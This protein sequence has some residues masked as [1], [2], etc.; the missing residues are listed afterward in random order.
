MEYST[1]MMDDILWIVSSGVRAMYKRTIESVIWTN[2]LDWQPS[3]YTSVKLP[4]IPHIYKYNIHTKQNVS[5]ETKMY[6]VR[7]TR[8]M[9]HVFVFILQYIYNIYCLHLYELWDSHLFAL[10]TSNSFVRCAVLATEPAR[11]LFLFSQHY[12]P[13]TEKALITHT[14][15]HLSASICLS[16]FLYLSL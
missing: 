15:K 14:S 9:C 3:L 8:I 12:I 6:S 2:Y 5:C 1:L 13:H 11:H 16:S 10:W 7:I 4:Y